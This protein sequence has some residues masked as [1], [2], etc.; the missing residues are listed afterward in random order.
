M[1][2][3]SALLRSAVACLV[4]LVAF[5]SVSAQAEV[6]LHERIDQLLESAA[7]APLPPQCDDAEFL[8]RVSLDLNGVI[9][10]VDE[11]RAFFADSNK[12]KRQQWIDRLLTDPRYA[13]HMTHVFDVNLMERRPDKG[14]KLADWQEYLYKS[15]V[16]NKPYNL[17]VREILAA[18]EKDPVGPITTKFYLDRDCEP[19]AITRDVARLFF[20]MDLQC[21]QCHDHPLVDDY[22]QSDYYGLY[23]FLQRTYQFADKKTKKNELAEKADGEASFK[24]VFTGASADKV[25]PRLPR[26]QMFVDPVLAKGEEYLV[27]PNPK[28]TAIKPVPK[29]S[30]RAKL[31]ELT[32]LGENDLFNRNIANRLWAVM[33]GRGLVHPLDFHHPDNPPSHPELLTLLAQE[34][35]AQKY[36]IKWF[37]RELALTRAYQRSSQL[38]SPSQLKVAEVSAK[39]KQFEAD[40]IK[41]TAAEKQAATAF[42]QASAQATE[43]RKKAAAPDAERDK[44]AAAVKEAQTAFDKVKAD[45]AAALKSQANLN[46]EQNRVRSALTAS[47]AALE[48]AKSDKQIKAA[49][50]QLEISIKNREPALKAADAKVT[51]AQAA[52]KQP[53]EKLNAAQAALKARALAVT[54][55]QITQ[56]EAVEAK[57][58]HQ[59]GDAKVAL[60][61]VKARLDEARKLIEYAELAKTDKAKADRAWQELSET[62]TQRCLLPSLRPIGGEAFALSLARAAGSLRIQEVVATAA[63]KKTPPKEMQEATAEAKP[64][65]EARLVEQQS[66]AAMRGSINP[67]ITLYADLPG[68]DFAATVNQALY[69]N[70]GG[71]IASWLAPGDNLVGRLQKLSDDAALADELYVSV[72]TRAPDDRERQAVLAFLKEQAGP[73]RLT[74]IQEMVWALLSSNEFRFNH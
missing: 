21:A 19:N 35:R 62:W 48:L 22:M 54:P 27:A 45:E 69:F 49:I 39:L 6:P 17:M 42:E 5:A 57:A 71:V 10:S 55:E 53:Q 25:L 74:G 64:K 26:G 4:L 37:V 12:N 11:A 29:V 43:L 9:P 50:A 65:I 59:A 8:R 51:Q 72:L 40:Q 3:A 14:I 20:G 52:L 60:A 47:Q 68:S 18:D 1:P 23:A 2:S 46:D 34:L 28:D 56:A 38:P 41:L 61:V 36:D 30:R 66:F 15:F 67:L 16:A 31:A 24:S 63:L 32:A 70:N 33:F 13:R 7:I 73:A 58:K 44:L